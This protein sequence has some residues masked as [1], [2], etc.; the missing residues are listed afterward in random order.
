MVDL[1]LER[2]GEKVILGLDAHF[3]ARVRVKALGGDF[4]RT[5]N[6]APIAGD[7]ETAFIAAARTER[8]S[9]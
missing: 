1:V 5:S 9:S 6:F 2:F 8:C 4:D 7:R 3:L